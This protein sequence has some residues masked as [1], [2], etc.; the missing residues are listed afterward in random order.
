MLVRDATGS[1]R[2]IWFNQPFLKDVFHPHQRVILFG[3]L[4]LTSHGLQMQSPQYE[5][6]GESRTTATDDDAARRRSDDDTLH[7]GRIVPIY[8]K[9][10]QLTRRCSARWCT[11][12][13]S[14]CRDDLPDPLPAACAQRQRADR[15]G[16]PRSSRCTSRRPT[17]PST[18][19]TRSASPA[20]RRLIFEE[21]FLFQLGI[22]LRRAAPTP[23]GR[24]RPVVVTDDDPRGG[25]ARC[26]RSS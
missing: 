5:I 22:V 14:S 4:E 20:Q 16:A 1:L 26:C 10:G 9:T 24:A 25:P 8:E 18:S 3:K 15:I 19:S 7:T 13:C 2:A 21:F 17:R 23:S 6:L 11:R 12:R